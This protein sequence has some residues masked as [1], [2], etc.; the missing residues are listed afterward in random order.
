MKSI[1]LRNCGSEGGE[2]K[3]HGFGAIFFFFFQIFK[4]LENSKRYLVSSTKCLRMAIN[5]FEIIMLSGQILIYRKTNTKHHVITMVLD[6]V[7]VL[8]Y[9]YSY[10]VLLFKS[11][12]ILS[13]A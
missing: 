13:W 1:T 6:Q 4:T 7:Y 2:L 5:N 10:K 12:G 11:E 9:T 3:N 8:T